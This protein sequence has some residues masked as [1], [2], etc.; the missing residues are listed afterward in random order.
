MQIRWSS[1]KESKSMLGGG[2]E[3]ELELKCAVGNSETE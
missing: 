3:T 2:E 1:G